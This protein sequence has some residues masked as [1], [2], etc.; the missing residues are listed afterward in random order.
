MNDTQNTNK[1]N[2]ENSLN[3][4]SA[5][6]DVLTDT[7]ISDKDSQDNSGTQVQNNNITPIDKP[8]YNIQNLKPYN[9]T[10]RILTK[11]EAKKRGSKGGIKS[12]EVRRQKKTMKETLENALKLELSQEKLEELGADTSLMN[13]EMTVLSAIV[14]STIREA[15]N[16][17]S[18]SIQFIRDSI[19]EQPT[20]K[21]EI[22]ETI[23]HDDA[24]MMDNLTKALI[25]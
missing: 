19:G 24:Q 13:G 20:I 2:T 12:G 16:G 25:G 15:I 7:D 9:K 4:I 22:T 3:N 1:Q 11:E 5:R 10:D 14:A 23:T 21:Q 18:K 6:S 17:D 8:K